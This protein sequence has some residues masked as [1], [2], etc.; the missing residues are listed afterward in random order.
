MLT[1]LHSLML[2]DGSFG[3]VCLKRL[4]LKNLLTIYPRSKCAAARKSANAGG[5]HEVLGRI[6]EGW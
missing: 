5:I 4:K 2:I 6:R 1:V 3:T